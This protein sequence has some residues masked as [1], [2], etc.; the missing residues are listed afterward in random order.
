MPDAVFSLTNMMIKKELKQPLVFFF[1]SVRKPH[2]FLFRKWRVTTLYMAARFAGSAWYRLRAGRSNGS[3][4][5]DEKKTRLSSGW[6]I[7]GK[8]MQG[9]T[10][11]LHTKMAPQWVSHLT[12][13]FQAHK[14]TQTQVWQPFSSNILSDTRSH[15]LRRI[16]EVELSIVVFYTLH[17]TTFRWYHKIEVH[18]SRINES[19]GIGNLFNDYNNW[20]YSRC[21]C[22]LVYSTREM[23]E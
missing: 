18:P 17:S 19:R 5:A 7:L 22:I 8:R 1:Q 21:T 6:I 20:S 16:P 15:V 23:H 3:S 14:L 9:R 12:F 13:H 2:K 11:A 4:R 10:G